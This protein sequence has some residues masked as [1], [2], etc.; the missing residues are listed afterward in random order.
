MDES[1]RVFVVRI[2]QQ[3]GAFRASVRRPGCDQPRWFNQAER[4]CD[5]LLRAGDREDAL[6]PGDADDHDRPA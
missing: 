6:L 2:W 1:L 4:L 5:Y 3:A